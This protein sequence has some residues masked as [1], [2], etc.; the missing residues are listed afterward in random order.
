MYKLLQIY[1]LREKIKTRLRESRLL[2]PSGR[3]SEFTQP[4]L[5]A[6]FYLAHIPLNKSLPRSI[7]RNDYYWGG[8][9]LSLEHR[10]PV[11]KRRLKFA[12]RPEPN[13][14]LTKIPDLWPEPDLWLAPNRRPDLW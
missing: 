13:L 1:L 8:E 9:R 2:A 4:S 5:L 6:F 7:C 14:W 11:F 3:W 10:L 12:L